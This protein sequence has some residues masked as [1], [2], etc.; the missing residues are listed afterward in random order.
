[1]RTTE[2]REAQSAARSPEEAA[3]PICK[4]SMNLMRWYDASTICNLLLISRRNLLQ[5]YQRSWILYCPTSTFEQRRHLISR[6]PLRTCSQRSKLM[7]TEVLVQFRRMPPQLLPWQ[8][9]PCCTL[10]QGVLLRWSGYMLSVSHE[11]QSGNSQEYM[12]ATY[13]EQA[14]KTRR[15]NSF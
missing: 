15:A 11:I 4:V 7:W 6:A 5:S 13:V 14:N 9:V 3:S 12:A 8:S 2:A 1:M 10:R